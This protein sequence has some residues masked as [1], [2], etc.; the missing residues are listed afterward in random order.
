MVVVGRVLFLMDVK[1]PEGDRLGEGGEE[2]GWGRRVRKQFQ[3]EDAWLSQKDG[4]MVQ[5]KRRSV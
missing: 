3:I 2:L 1:V 5:F 4:P